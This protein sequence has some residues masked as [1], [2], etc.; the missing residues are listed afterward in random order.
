VIM[1]REILSRALND[2]NL[3]TLAGASDPNYMAGLVGTFSAHVAKNTDI[4]SVMA[5]SLY[6]K[7]A[8]RFVNTVVH[9]YQQWHMDQRLLGVA[10]TLNELNA[11]LAKYEGELETK[12]RQLLTEEE[13]LG[14]ATGSSVGV[15]SEKLEN[16][17]KQ[18][19]RAYV[20]AEEFRRYYEGLQRYETKPE[21]FRM[22]AVAN[23][24]SKGFVVDDRERVRLEEE[25]RATQLQ[26]DAIEAGAVVQRSRITQLE[27]RQ[28]ELEKKKGEFDEEFVR[29]HLAEAKTRL[30][31]TASQAS[32]MAQAYNDEK[33]EL[34]T[35]S[36]V[37]GRYEDLLSDCRSLEERCR[38][39]REMITELKIQIPPGLKIHVLEKAIPAARPTSVQTARVLGIGLVAGMMMGSGLAFVRDW[40]DQRVR[41]ADE[42]TAILGVPVLGAIPTIS[43]RTALG[44]GKRAMFSSNS[45]ESEACRAI[46]TALFFGVPHDQAT[47]LLITSPGPREGKTTLVSNL[48]IAMA[49]AGQKT[50]IIDADLRKP[51]QQRV[52]A[53]KGTGKGLTDLLA[54]TAELDETIRTTKVQG[55][56]VLG[57]G[58]NVPNPSEMLNSQV[59]PAVLE[60]LRA[61]YDRIIV[62]SPPVGLV[63]DGQILATM[64]DLTLIVLRAKLST[65]QV[66]QR[67][68]DALRTVGARIAGAVVND[69]SKRDRQYSHYS[70]YGYYYGSHSESRTKVSKELPADVTPD[71]EDGVSASG[72]K[73]WDNMFP[74]S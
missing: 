33:G 63:T 67:A 3:L 72:E 64:C 68:R 47:T 31:D 34:R 22:Y 29:G 13:R 18:W 23:G 37:A 73:Q 35:T 50:L 38:T 4:I 24:L 62:D 61:R 20:E 54:G 9:S 2:P 12:R 51:M 27:E 46:R 43:R 52:F 11:E 42:I 74:E 59:L 5:S 53:M 41:S 66:T 16:L 57:S 56:D 58:Q 30:D 65:R 70:G 8:A 7:D 60:Q 14:A 17:K 36:N 48:G 6:P 39:L 49:Q 19:D 71:S 55:L 15:E 21:Q 1:S 32:Q 44:R 45:R 10:G 69:V 40:R 26:L 28:V 25:L